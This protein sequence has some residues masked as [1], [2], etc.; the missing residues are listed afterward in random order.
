MDAAHLTPGYV[1]QGFSY[2]RCGLYKGANW[3]STKSS[4]AGYLA[5]IPA[6]LISFA[7]TYAELPIRIIEDLALTAINLVGAI[8][9]KGCHRNLNYSF[10]CIRDDISDSFS[11]LLIFYFK[12][13]TA[14]IAYYLA[15]QAILNK[16]SY[17]KNSAD[18]HLTAV[19]RVKAI[20]KL[21]YPAI[22]KLE[23]YI[24]KTARQL[25]ASRSFLE[26]Y[27][28]LCRLNTEEFEAFAAGLKTPLKNPW[29]CP[30]ELKNDFSEHA[31]IAKRVLQLCH[32]VDLSKMLPSPIKAHLCGL[33]ALP[34][35][36]TDKNIESKKK[37]MSRLLHPDKN[38]GKTCY[39]NALA[40][41]NTT[42]DAWKR[43]R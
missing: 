19:Y 17:L 4:T 28:K 23:T 34:T 2:A 9:A 7:T 12:W 27:K 37:K 8:F 31:E 14:A 43:T 42:F 30:E 33:M 6:A 35:D 39:N 1:K 15:I 29:E 3:T 38:E 10:R 13:V 41:L 26:L 18:F 36:T 24:P 40:A 21:G 20:R 32:E 11:A 25:I 16:N 5:C 22:Q